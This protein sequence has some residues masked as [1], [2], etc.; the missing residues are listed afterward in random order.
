MKEGRTVSMLARHMGLGRWT[1]QETSISQEPRRGEAAVWRK[2][3]LFLLQ[4][5]TTAPSCPRKSVCAYNMQKC[6]AQVAYLETHRAICLFCHIFHWPPQSSADL[7]S[8]EHVF[9][10]WEKD[11]VREAWKECSWSHV[12]AVCY[13]AS[14]CKGIFHFYFRLVCKLWPAGESIPLGSYAM[15]S[16]C[17]PLFRTH[18]PQ[19]CGL[20]QCGPLP[21]AT[22]ESFSEQTGPLSSSRASLRVSCCLVFKIFLINFIFRAF[23]GSYLH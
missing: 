14:N 3:L 15:R 1:R 21:G 11:G 12:G 17:S 9:L 23:L 16:L 18:L 8:W 19:G 10:S 22:A 7:L 13:A 20:A 2:Q 4:G 6:A 5:Q